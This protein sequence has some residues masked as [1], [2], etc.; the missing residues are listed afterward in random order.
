MKILLVHKYHFRFGGAEKIYFETA[1][2]LRA[3][4]HEVAFF[5]MRHPKNELTPWEKYFVDYVDFDDQGK[6][7]GRKLMI[8]WRIIWNQQA[9][10]NLNA[11]IDEFQPDVAHC[12]NVYHQLS[13]SVLQAL[14]RKHIPIVLTLCDFKAVSP[15]Y[16]LYNFEKRKI[17]DSASGV[18]CIFDRVIKHSM[19]KSIVCACEQWLHRMLKSYAHVSLY[20]APSD[21]LISKYH[22]LGFVYPIKRIHHPV[23]IESGSGRDSSVTGVGALPWKER[24]ETYIYFGRLSPEKG[25]DVLIR[26]FSL[27]P[28]K[29]L[30]IVGFGPEEEALKKLVI[31]S[32]M[33]QRVVFTGA[34]YSEALIRLI[35][36]SRAVIMPAVWYENQPFVLMDSLRLDTP[37]IASHIGGIPDIIQDTVNGFLFKPGDSTDLA[38]CITALS[39]YD[40]EQIIGEAKKSAG[41]YTDT[42]YLD[43]ILSA[44]SEA[45]ALV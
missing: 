5:S 4:G 22:A 45:I 1:R 9:V 41:E 2:L 28:G 17:W 13:P 39:K 31:D 24:S 14:S 43:E 19:A 21:F 32:N 7:F 35:N 38:T 6:S 36:Q 15:N 37:V 25:V 18:R 44:Y 12:F 16:F 11:L 34:V 33:S 27:L 10:R 23:I 40:I 8:A 20:L 3:A 26:A 29:S 30:T 42:R